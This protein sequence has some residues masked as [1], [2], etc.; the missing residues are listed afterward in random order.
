MTVIDK[1]F[2]RKS[3]NAS[4]ATYD[5][6]AG[7]QK[8][9]IETLIGELCREDIGPQQVLDIGMGTG[10]LTRRLTNR[11]PGARVYGCDLADRM[12]SLAR[13]KF[14]NPEAHLFAAADAECLP[15]RSGAFDLVVS[16]FT[17]QWLETWEHA[18]GEVK[19]A[20]AEKGR[21]FFT[22]FGKQTFN[23][24]RHSYVQ[25]CD[26][27]GYT[28]G[29][30][31]E[32]TITEDRIRQRLEQCGFADATTRSYTV[33]EHYG[34]VADLVRTIKGMGARN[35]SGNRNRTP[36][37]R[38][39]W[40]RMVDIYERTYGGADGIPATYEIVLGEGLK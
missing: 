34:S 6:N 22:A 37:V 21:F 32:L 17:Y 10:N 19:R 2:V 38:K 20:L 5:D 31:L 3:F 4:A 25:A 23:E 12:I 30:A 8:R 11:F 14:E 1:R 16:S 29:K 15:Y 33:L 27:T 9:L 26:E 18:F 28:K 7:L 40:K 13:N 36:G 35:A 24:L 39:I